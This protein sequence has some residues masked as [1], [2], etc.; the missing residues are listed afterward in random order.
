MVATVV[1]TV[2]VEMLLWLYKCNC[3]SYYG[4]CGSYSRYCGNYYQHRNATVV[5]TVAAVVATSD[6]R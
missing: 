3:G 5:V 2:L 4:Y 1:P 6:Q